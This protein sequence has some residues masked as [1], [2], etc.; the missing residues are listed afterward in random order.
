MQSTGAAC[1]L[2]P[3]VRTWVSCDDEAYVCTLRPFRGYHVRSLTCLLCEH[4]GSLLDLNAG[5]NSTTAL[6]IHN[7]ICVNSFHFSSTVLDEILFMS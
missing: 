3:S 6:Q 7:V 5:P 4:H 2:Q 1:V